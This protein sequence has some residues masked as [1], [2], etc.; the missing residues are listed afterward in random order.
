MMENFDQ[1]DTQ[2][3][4]NELEDTSPLGINNAGAQKLIFR[5]FP[6]WLV[7]ILAV[8][9]IGFMLTVGGVAGYQSGKQ[10]LNNT[11]SNLSNQSLQEQYDLGVQNFQAGEYEL[12]L[13]RFQYV[14]TQDPGYP[15][16]TDRIA[17]VMLIVYATATPVPQATA[18]PATATAD[19][20]PVEELFNQAQIKINNQDWSGGIDTLL[21][22]R[23]ADQ[24]YKVARVDGL[25]YITHRNRG[26]DKILNQRDLEGGNYDLAIAAKFGPLDREAN[27]AREWARLYIIG[28][29]FWEV[30]PEQ[31]VFYF[32]QV[33]SSAPY[34]S[35]ASGWTAT[36]RYRVALMQFAG[37][38]SNRGNWCA[39]QQQYEL[40][41]A[42]RPDENVQAL[43]EEAA[44]KCSPPT[45]T[46]IITEL[47]PTPSVTEAAPPTNQIPPTT[48]AP[49][50]TEIPPG[51]VVPPTTEAPATTESPPTTEIPP[52]T[53]PPPETTEPVVTTEA[54]VTTEPPVTTESPDVPEIPS[55]QSTRQVEEPPT[56]GSS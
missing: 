45:P 14:L 49:P 21:A 29:S 15:G 46:E 20:R 36:E 6:L 30:H 40:A 52:T 34:L 54:P 37:F 3:L 41:L 55:P 8:F 5:G 32:G 10:Y 4:E 33:A 26:V 44:I 1:K 38:L 25:L 35:D 17:D 12:A 9:V 7:G 53:E 27:S 51:T 23:K 18:I 2:P 39:A 13:Q 19:M 11:S 42:V 48:Q 22:L 56:E 31:A 24:N 16:I 50:D 47:P 28:L 43:A